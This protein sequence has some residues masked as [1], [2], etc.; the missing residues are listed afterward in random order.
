MFDKKEF[1]RLFWP[2]LIEQTLT[3]TIGM[4]NTMMVSGV[5]VEAISAVSIVDSLNFVIVN[6][7]IAFST[8]ATVV[9][10]QQIGAG[11]TDGAFDTA[12]QSM[13]ACVFTAVLSS[14]A[15]II[16]GNSIISWLFGNAEE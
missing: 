2:V 7:F 3:V 15:F 1:L 6:L 4:V 9:I 14:I 10:A 11:Q 5:G 12:S 8:G 13:T 16:F